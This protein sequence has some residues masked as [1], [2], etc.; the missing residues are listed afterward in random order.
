MRESQVGSGPL[1][2]VGQVLNCSY[3]SQLIHTLTRIS[4]GV[5]WRLGWYERCVYVHFKLKYHGFIPAWSGFLPSV[6]WI[7]SFRRSDT[8]RVTPCLSEWIGIHLWPGSY[9]S[10]AQYAGKLLFS[11]THISEYTWIRVMLGVV[12]TSLMY[13]KVKTTHARPGLILGGLLNT[14]LNLLFRAIRPFH[15]LRRCNF[16]NPPPPPCWIVFPLNTVFFLLNT[17]FLPL[18]TVFLWIPYPFTEH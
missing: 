16:W 3:L 6:G 13:C 7:R 12:W 8:S 1:P 17:I 4:V 10:A 11:V 2:S 14:H 5:R 9:P 18:N 15:H